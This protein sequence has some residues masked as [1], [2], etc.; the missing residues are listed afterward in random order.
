MRNTAEVRPASGSEVTVRIKGGLTNRSYEVV[1]DAAD[2]RSLPIAVFLLYRL[3]VLRR[4]A[5][6][7]SATRG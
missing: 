3:A 1:F 6:R 5:Y 7:T 2:E 4:E